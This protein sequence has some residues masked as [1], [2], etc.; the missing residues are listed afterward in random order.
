MG[1]DLDPFLRTTRRV[2]RFLPILTLAGLTACVPDREIL[3]TLTT[4]SP[5]SD[6]LEATVNLTPTPAIAIA[7]A[8]ST[9]RI[10]STP[11]PSI[12]RVKA[13]DIN[14]PNLDEL[15]TRL[16]DLRRDLSARGQAMSITYYYEGNRQSTPLD[17]SARVVAGI[18]INFRQLPILDPDSLMHGVPNFSPGE[19]MKHKYTV[20][21]KDSGI[22]FA[23]TEKWG[24]RG[25]AALGRLTIDKEGQVFNEMYASQDISGLKRAEVDW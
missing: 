11:T 8:S 20:I 4:R 7:T 18:G 13:S 24:R 15:M 21:K 5:G 1:I 12:D 10:E 23:Y 2:A 17:V 25:F 22:S 9:P 19:D 14:D 6:R 16:N 3:P